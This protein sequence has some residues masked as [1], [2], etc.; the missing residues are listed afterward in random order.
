M[1]HWQSNL[2]NKLPL[3]ANPT[4]ERRKK[5]KING[6]IVVT[7]QKEVRLCCFVLFKQK[8]ILVQPNPLS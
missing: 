5:E 7:L 2:L 4:T 8:L 1:N 6:V 3:K